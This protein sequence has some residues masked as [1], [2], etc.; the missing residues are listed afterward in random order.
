M[1]C[2]AALP[3]SGYHSSGKHPIGLV[4]LICENK[5]NR[6]VGGSEFIPSIKVQDTLDFSSTPSIYQLK[7]Q[8]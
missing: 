2:A 8:K 6:I 4:C 1:D 3:Q 7:D 5:R